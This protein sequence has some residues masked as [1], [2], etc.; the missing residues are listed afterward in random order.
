M[1]GFYTVFYSSPGIASH[2]LIEE[3]Q[4]LESRIDCCSQ[5]C[6][7][8]RAIHSFACAREPSLKICCYLPLEAA[9]SMAVTVALLHVLKNAKNDWHHS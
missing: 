7:I 5:P 4:L 9:H 6:D 3:F 1:D 2:L 8:N